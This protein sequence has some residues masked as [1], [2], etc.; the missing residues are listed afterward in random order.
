MLHLF[1]AV[2]LTQPFRF[3]SFAAALLSPLLM[4]AS[5]FLGLSL[6]PLFLAAGRWLSGSFHR[7]VCPPRGILRS[8]R[9]P[10]M[11]RRD[12]CRLNV[13][14]SFI[15]FCLMERKGGDCVQ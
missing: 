6:S 13:S 2:A 11:A 7:R 8:P 3:F 10:A 12:R 5:L 14:M 9:R 4:A 1:S 15:F